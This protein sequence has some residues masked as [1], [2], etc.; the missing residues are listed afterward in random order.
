LS[1]TTAEKAVETQY[2]PTP[3]ELDLARAR[4]FE[5]LLRELDNVQRY[6]Q[7]RFRFI[8]GVGLNL[9]YSGSIHLDEEEI[10]FEIRLHI[11]RKVICE[12]ARAMKRRVLKLPKRS[13]R[14]RQL[15]RAGDEVIE[16]IE[17]GDYRF[18]ADY[19]LVEFKKPEG[20]SERGEGD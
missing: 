12:V 2:E 10:A 8:T 15:E 16:A 7:H 3:I 4:I 17:K 18:M 5:Y 14:I 11:P 19:T 6:W 13:P 1:E 20:E 9:S